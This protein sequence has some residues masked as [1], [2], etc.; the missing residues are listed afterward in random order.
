MKVA[1]YAR[2]ST[3]DKDQNPEVQLA[4][5]REYCRSMGWEIYREYADKAS[6]VDLV[7]RTAWAAMMKSASLHKFDILFVY[8]MSRAFR[9]MIHAT[10]TL[11]TLRAYHVDFRSYNDMGVD[12]STPSGELVYHILAACAQFDREMTGIAVRAGMDYAQKH[13]T[14]SGLPIG[15]RQVD[16]TF[17]SICKALRDTSKTGTDYNLSAA[18][19]ALSERSGKANVSAAFVLMRIRRQAEVCNIPEKDLISKILQ[20]KYDAVS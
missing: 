15:R 12:T 17:A 19:R 11:N 16:I 1:L 3:V 18:A 8:S 6:A 9:S 4:K 20:E 14:K 2:V 7:N 5:L 13:G 10:N